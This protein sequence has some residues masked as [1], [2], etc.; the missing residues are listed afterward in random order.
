MFGVEYGVLILWDGKEV[1]EQS[2]PREGK[3]KDRV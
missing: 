3:I 2:A 1:S